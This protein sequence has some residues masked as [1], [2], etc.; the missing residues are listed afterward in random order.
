MVKI[1]IAQTPKN[2]AITQTIGDEA[3]F[4]KRGKE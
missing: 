1:Q 2:T 4:T 3:S